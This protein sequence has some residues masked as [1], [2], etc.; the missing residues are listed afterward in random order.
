MWIADGTLVVAFTT[1]TQ[2][3]ADQLRGLGIGAFTTVRVDRSLRQLVH[4]QKQ[5][6]AEVRALARLGCTL[7]GIALRPDRNCV[8]VRVLGDDDAASK[9]LVRRYGEGAIEVERRPHVVPAQR[10]P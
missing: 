1:D 5:V 9:Y 10:E 3:Y 6:S 2:F 8:V 4:L 7:T